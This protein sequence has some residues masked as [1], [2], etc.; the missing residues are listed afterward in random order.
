VQT[1]EGSRE[2]SPEVAGN[3]RGLRA[4]QSVRDVADLRR[5]LYVDDSSWWL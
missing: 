1:V 4:D 2:G 3:R 5:R